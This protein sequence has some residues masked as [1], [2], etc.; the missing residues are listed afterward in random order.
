MLHNLSTPI[1]GKKDESNKDL[2]VRLAQVVD[3]L[4]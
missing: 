3:I 4:Q 1:K 2:K